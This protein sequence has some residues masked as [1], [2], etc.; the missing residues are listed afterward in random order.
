MNDVWQFLLTD[1]QGCFDTFEGVYVFGS[2]LWS[3]APRDLDILLVYEASKLHLVA[4]AERCIVAQMSEWF[5]ALPAH[6][7]TL[8]EAE[9]VSTAFLS[10][11][12]SVR[13]K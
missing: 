12:V 3:P 2:M 6:L 11:I 9:L 7:T 8:N 4:D 1:A 13:I 5:P 10:R